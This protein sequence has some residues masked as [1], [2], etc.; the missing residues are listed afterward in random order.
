MAEI[1]NRVHLFFDSVRLRMQQDKKQPRILSLTMFTKSCPTW[2]CTRA[3]RWMKRQGNLSKTK[4][5][6][7]KEYVIKGRISQNS[8][9]TAVSHLG[10]I[11]KSPSQMTLLLQPLF[12]LFAYSG[13][14]PVTAYPFIFAFVFL[15]VKNRLQ[16]SYALTYSQ[17]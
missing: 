4:D 12:P 17:P 8:L 5:V 7:N 6:R 9:C 1:K 15:T 11:F 3:L 10:V 16:V 14:V 13:F 2:A